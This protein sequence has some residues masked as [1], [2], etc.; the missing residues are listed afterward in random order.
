[1]RDKIKSKQYFDEFIRED[2]TRILNLSKKIEE[3]KIKEARIVPVKQ[4]I[5][6]IKLGIIIAKYSRG[7]SIQDLELSFVPIYKEWI[8][9]FFSPEVYNENLKMISLAVLFNMEPDLLLLVKKKL[10]ENH[11]DDWL[12]NFLLNE[13]QN[14]SGFLFPKRFRIFKEIAESANKIE[15]L[16]QYLN[17]DWYNTDCEVFEAHKSAQKIYYGYW[18][19]EAGAAV[20]ILGIDDSGLKDIPYYPYDLVHYKE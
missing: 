3:G 10:I 12:Y 18:S 14:E 1:M 4:G 19:F 13:K 7:D 2:H 17:K 16:N 9:T 11:I 8:K 5:F 6:R 20:K 15:L